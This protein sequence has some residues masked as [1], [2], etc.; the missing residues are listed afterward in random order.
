M[1]MGSSKLSASA[2]MPNDRW[3][4][5]RLTVSKHRARTDKTHPPMNAARKLALNIV[6]KESC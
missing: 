6:F 1:V 2:G 5:L 3:L 4:P